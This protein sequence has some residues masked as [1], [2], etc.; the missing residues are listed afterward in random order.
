MTL[1]II[2]KADWYVHAH[3]HVITDLQREF[4]KEFYYIGTI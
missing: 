2:D 1:Q 3:T 4:T